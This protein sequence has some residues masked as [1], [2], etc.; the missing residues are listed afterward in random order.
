MVDAD[1]ESGAGL[2]LQFASM[3]EPAH[4]QALRPG[5]LRGQNGPVHCWPGVEH[6]EQGSIDEKLDLVVVSVGCRHA[7]NQI[8][9]AVADFTGWLTLSPYLALVYI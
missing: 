6:D 9:H 3:G 2:G 5:P 8:V 7:L 1:L 4:L